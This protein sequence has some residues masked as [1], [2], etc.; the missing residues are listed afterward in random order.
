MINP[1]I[2]L[3]AVLGEVGAI[4]LL[5]VMVE[6]WHPTEAG[7]RRAVK[8]AWLGVAALLAAW[9]F[10]GWYYVAEYGNAI[11]PIIKAGPLPWT[12]SVIMETKEHLFLFL[13]FLAI[14]IVACISRVQS[15]R[16]VLWLAGMAVVTIFSIA[17]MGWLVSSGYRAA[18]E[19]TT[20]L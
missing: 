10:G 12:H 11:K 18:L 17:G 6:L 7:K 14:L 20:T 3:H 9:V 2:G 19:V 8:A 16:P 1:L 13:P 5:W 15:Y 4:A